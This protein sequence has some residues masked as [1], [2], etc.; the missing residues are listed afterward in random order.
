MQDELLIR[1]IDGKCTRE[2]SEKVIEK[3]SRDGNEAA[4]WLQMV[5][6]AR[7]ADSKPVR[8]VPPADAHSFVSGTVQRTTEAK[9][10]HRRVVRWAGIMAVPCAVA[11]LSEP[12]MTGI[13]RNL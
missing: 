10:R 1:F 3:L 12:T 13:I 5:A 4:E 2:E 9:A 6:A 7:L 8:S 11:A